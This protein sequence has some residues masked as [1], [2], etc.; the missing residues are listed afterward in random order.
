[1]VSEDSTSRVIVFPVRVLTNI[2]MASE[3]T[4][5]MMNW[6]EMEKRH[7][8]EWRPLYRVDYVML[9]PEMTPMATSVTFS[10]ALEA[11]YAGPVFLAALTCL[12][13]TAFNGRE[14]SCNVHRIIQL[15]CTLCIA[16]PQH[17]QD[18]FWI[19]WVSR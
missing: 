11:M 8:Y 17:Q 1:M 19:G 10:G 6:E 18:T 4:W 3:A 16:Q 12:E 7:R 2:C 9:M 15:E 14:W 13:R 5:V